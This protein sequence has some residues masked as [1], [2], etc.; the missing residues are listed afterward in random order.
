M[1]NGYTFLCT[2][3]GGRCWEETIHPEWKLLMILRDNP[4]PRTICHNTTIN[5]NTSVIIS[6]LLLLWFIIIVKLV[7]FLMSMLLVDC[8]II[9]NTLYIH[10]I[11]TLYIYTLYIY[12]LRIY[13]LHIGDD[14]NR[15]TQQRPGESR[16]IC[17]W[18]GFFNWWTLFRAAAWDGDHREL[19]PP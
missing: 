13:I 15:W 9:Q 7:F 19:I 8:M 14:Q 6:I 1:L 11:F 4:C 12:T 3:L 5:M 18:T 10:N 16:Q 17:T 2:L